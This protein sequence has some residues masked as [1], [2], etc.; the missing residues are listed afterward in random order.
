M[1]EETKSEKLILAFDSSEQDDFMLCKRRWHLIHHLDLRSVTS[2]YALDR[3]TLLH[4][5]L[6]E[7]YRLKMQN[8]EEQ[9]AIERSIEKGRKSSLE[10]EGLNNQECV[11]VYFQFREYCRYWSDKIEL[12]YPLQI[13][14]PFFKKIYEDDQLI[15]GLQGI[16]DYLGKYI[17]TDGIVVVDHKGVSQ[18]TEYSLLRNQFKNYCIAAE[19]DTAIVNK[20]GFQ[21]TL[22]PAE[23]FTRQTI[24]YSKDQ[25]QEQIEVL[26]ATGK[27]M[28]VAMKSEYY[29]PNFT[30]CDKY[31]GCTFAE[32]FCSARPDVRPLR[33]GTYFVVGK[34]WD[35]GKVL[36]EKK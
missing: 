22:S 12:F 32:H 30:S 7:Y 9:V 36:E 33:I 8:I 24:T 3:G 25:L 27:E 35:V 29:P 31:A 5:L 28:L 19:T 4:L 1:S 2:I 20:I 34:K 16:I 6:A 17:G 14:T 23:R 26:T 18:R 21:K 15:I 10:I 13:E 11:E